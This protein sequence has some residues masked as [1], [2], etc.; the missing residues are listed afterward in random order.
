MTEFTTTPLPPGYNRIR[1]H[2]SSGI[3]YT[4]QSL[5]VWQSQPTAGAYVVEKFWH[6]ID[7]VVASLEVLCEAVR[8]LEAELEQTR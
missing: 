5:G 6:P 3:E 8:G 2:T 7:A 1:I 4:T